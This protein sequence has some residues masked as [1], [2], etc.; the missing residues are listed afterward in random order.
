MLF[1]SRVSICSTTIILYA[2]I[3]D[4][5]KEAKV[6]LISKVNFIKIYL[7]KIKNTL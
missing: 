7:N 1:L 3:I 4:L 2:D 6:S 5:F